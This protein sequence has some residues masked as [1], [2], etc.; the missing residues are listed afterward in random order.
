M[1]IGSSMAWTSHAGLNPDSG[2]IRPLLHIITSLF[3]HYYIITTALLYIIT[4]VTTLWLRLMTEI[5]SLLLRI[6]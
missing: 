1:S 4:F 3:L 5:M 6:I 2:S